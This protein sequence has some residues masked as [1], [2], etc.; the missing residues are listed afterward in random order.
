MTRVKTYL[1]SIPERRGPR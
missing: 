1:R